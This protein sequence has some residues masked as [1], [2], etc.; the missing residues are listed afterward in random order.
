M[1]GSQS[2]LAEGP[3]LAHPLPLTGVAPRA[4]GRPGRRRRC[5]WRWPSTTAGWSSAHRLPGTPCTGPSASSL[6]TAD[7]QTREQ[8]GEPAPLAPA[9]PSGTL[10]SPQ[11]PA[12]SFHRRKP[13]PGRVP[14]RWQQHRW[15]PSVSGPSPGLGGDT[16]RQVLPKATGSCE[17]PSLPP[18]RL[19]PEPVDTCPSLPRCPSPTSRDSAC[20]RNSPPAHYRRCLCAGRALTALP[21]SL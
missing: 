2:S 18:T 10:P 20:R 19:G 3:A 4:R 14:S 16:Q 12:N 15:L 13:L 5:W 8:Q 11:T 9:D 1:E 17:P 7:T 21:G 6:W